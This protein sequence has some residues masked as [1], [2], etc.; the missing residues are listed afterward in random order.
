MRFL[1]RPVGE[2]GQFRLDPLVALGDLAMVELV[3]RV[4]LLKLEEMFGP[5]CS[6]Q[7][8]GN[9]WLAV[10]ALPMTQL[11]QFVGVAFAFEDGIQCQ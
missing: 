2:L 7:R 11:G 3:Q 6:V 8:K 5:P 1:P 9:L 4:R 10:M